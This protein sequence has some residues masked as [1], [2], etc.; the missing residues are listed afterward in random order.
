MFSIALFEKG[1][2][3][4]LLLGRS[5]SASACMMAGLNYSQGISPQLT[6]IALG[7]NDNQGGGI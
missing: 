1:P 5:V 2:A 3:I 6:A 4:Y 7:L